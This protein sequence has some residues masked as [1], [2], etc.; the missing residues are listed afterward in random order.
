MSNTLTVNSIENIIYRAFDDVY[1][2][3]SVLSIDEVLAKAE[4][5]TLKELSTFVRVQIE[6]KVIL[7]T[8]VI[9]GTIILMR[10]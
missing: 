9:I 6:Q 3:L 1:K 5:S 2:I 7:L 8:F 10:S 4:K